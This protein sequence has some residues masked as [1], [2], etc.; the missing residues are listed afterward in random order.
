M[1][2]NTG[3]R[4]DKAGAGTGFGGEQCPESMRPGYAAWGHRYLSQSMGAVRGEQ[5]E[6]P[7]CLENRPHVRKELHSSG[8]LGR[9]TGLPE[10]KA[11]AA[12]KKGQQARTEIPEK[13]H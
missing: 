1:K 7:R 5:R 9:E 2:D 4:Q 10:Q 6:A 11:G 12:G 3:K 13:D 8:G